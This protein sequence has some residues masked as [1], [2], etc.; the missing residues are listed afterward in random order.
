MIQRTGTQAHLTPD[1]F[2][3]SRFKQIETPSYADIPFH[4]LER[5]GRYIQ[6]SC[7]NSLQKL[8]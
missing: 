1:R 2:K 4:W 3:R 6:P 5:Y 8:L 7:F